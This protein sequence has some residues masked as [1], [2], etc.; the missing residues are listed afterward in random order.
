MCV[1]V[2]VGGVGNERFEGAV[3]DNGEVRVRLNREVIGEERKLRK[4]NRMILDL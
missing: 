4:Y 2:C 1:F 3:Y